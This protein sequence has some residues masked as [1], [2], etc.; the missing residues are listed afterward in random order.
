MYISLPPSLLEHIDITRLFQGATKTKHCEI[1]LLFP[2]SAAGAA[3]KCVCVYIYIYDSFTQRENLKRYGHC[4]CAPNQR[5]LRWACCKHTGWGVV[6][7]AINTFSFWILDWAWLSCVRILFCME[8]TWTTHRIGPKHSKTF[9]TDESKNMKNMTWAFPVTGKKWNTQC[10]ASN[11]LDSMDSMDSMWD[12]CQTD[13]RCL[14]SW[15]RRLR[16]SNSAL[17]SDCS[18]GSEDFVAGMHCLRSDVTIFTI[19]LVINLYINISKSIQIYQILP[20]CPNTSYFKT[21]HDMTT[22]KAFR[23]FQMRH[24]QSFI[25]MRASRASR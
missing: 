13:V 18:L 2:G 4:V 10:S 20:A 15:D 14:N 9:W 7:W 25:A 11:V 5:K 12:S 23:L 8:Q 17:G 24:S 3:L 16:K 22:W 6:R 1:W 21:W 19:N